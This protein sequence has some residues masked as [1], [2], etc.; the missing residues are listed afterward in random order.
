MWQWC[1]DAYVASMNS[2]EAIA[3]YQFLKEDKANDGSSLGVLRGA[4]WGDEDEIVLR[5]AFRYGLDA[6]T[7]SVAFGFRCVLVVSGG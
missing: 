4:S 7:R 6:G 5:S 2:A 1:D 3:K